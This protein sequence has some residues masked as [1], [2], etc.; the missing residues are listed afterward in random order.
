[1]DE[2]DD[3]ELSDQDLEVLRKYGNSATFLDH[4]DQKGIAM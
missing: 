3:L 1:M 4:L 2:M